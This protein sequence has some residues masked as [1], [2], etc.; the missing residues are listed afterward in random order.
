MPFAC[1]RGSSTTRLWWRPR[2]WWRLWH[3]RRRCGSVS[4]CAAPIYYVASSA[5]WRGTGHGCGNRCMHYTG[6][7]AAQ[8]PLGNI[9]GAATQLDSAWLALFVGLPTMLLLSPEVMA[10]MLDR[11]SETAQLVKSL[12]KANAELLHLTLHDPLTNLALLHDCIDQCVERW[13][14]E[15]DRFVVTNVGL[16]TDSRR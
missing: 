14:C 10:S 15:H 5:G 12:G 3:R 16:W 9:C 13:R 2:W 6:M 1:S 4:T 8:F 11:R 7:A